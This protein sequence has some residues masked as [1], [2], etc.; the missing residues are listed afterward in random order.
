VLLAT[1]EPRFG[2][3]T[4]SERALDGSTVRLEGPSL[5]LLE[6]DSD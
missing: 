1:E 5:V 3:K 4:P 2:G 6:A